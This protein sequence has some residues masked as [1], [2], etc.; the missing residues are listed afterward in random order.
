MG[1]FERDFL[2]LMADADVPG[3]AAATVRDG[4]PERYLCCGIRNWHTR[5]AVESDTIFEAAPLGLATQKLL[6]EFAVP[7]EMLVILFNRPSICS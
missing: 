7:R 1:S 2:Q 5:A 4:H 3:L 6:E